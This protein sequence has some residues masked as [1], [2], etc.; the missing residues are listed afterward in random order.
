VKMVVTQPPCP[1]T[2]FAH[3]HGEQGTRYV[4]CCSAIDDPHDSLYLHMSTRGVELEKSLAQRVAPQTVHT[5]GSLCVAFP[6]HEKDLEAD[7][8][9]RIR[10]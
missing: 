10:A 2:E 7:Y 9:V 4:Q 6:H 1:L 5:Y 8:Q 3:E